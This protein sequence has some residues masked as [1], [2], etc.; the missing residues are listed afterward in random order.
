MSLGKRVARL[1]IAHGESLRE[2]AIRTGV[3][4]ST[5]A[6]IEKGEVTASFHETLQ[7]VADGYQVSLDFLVTG[8]LH[9]GSTRTSH[10]LTPEDKASLLFSSGRERL[11]RTLTL[12]T[13]RRGGITREQFAASLGLDLQTLESA[14]NGECSLPEALTEQLCDQLALLSGLSSLWFHWGRAGESEEDQ[15]D[16][17]WSRYM[18]IVEKSFEADL[19]PDLVEMA[20][21]LLRLNGAAAMP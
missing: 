12:V 14:L 7:K 10:R 1:R 4:H 3:S 19:Q 2:A 17:D 9:P 13:T 16:G 11:H 5:I 8:E 18:Q 15:I 20:I 21:D 6:R